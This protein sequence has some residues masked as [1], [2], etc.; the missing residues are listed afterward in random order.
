MKTP[1]ITPDIL[2]VRLQHHGIICTS[3]N[4][5]GYDGYTTPVPGGGGTIGDEGGVWTK[6]S[7]NVWDEEW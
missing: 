1:Y 5:N 7:S 4:P 3:T 6:E 2:E